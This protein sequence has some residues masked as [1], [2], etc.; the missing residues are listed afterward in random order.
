MLRSR[1]TGLL[2][3]LLAA[4]VFCSQPVTANAAEFSQLPAGTFG[5]VSIG[6]WGE[7]RDGDFEK[8]RAFLLQPGNLK[9]YGNYIWLDSQ[10]GNLIE[11]MKFAQLFEKSSASVAVGSESRCYSACFLLF[12][13]GV[14]RLLYPFAELGV[15]RISANG[16]GLSDAARTGLLQNIG[17]QVDSYLRAQGMPQPVLDEMQATPA[18][19]MFIIDR[20][21]LRRK[22]WNRA[23]LMQPAFL[24]MVEKACGP[25]PEPDKSVFDQQRDDSARERMKPWSA[26]KLDVQARATRE[27]V[28]AEL[29]LVEAGKPSLLFAAGKAKEAAAAASALR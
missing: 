26:C 14:D 24:D 17:K 16:P 28:E 1:I 23:M 11:A 2:S 6:I 3:A 9:A 27:F 7:I 8:F 22:G 4:A 15:H 18:T 19:S 13:G 29:A 20:L 12:A 21:M 5:P 10:G 25:H